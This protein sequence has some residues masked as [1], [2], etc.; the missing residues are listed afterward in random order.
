MATRDEFD[1]ANMSPAE[2]M[3]VAA[4]FLK[5]IGDKGQM[6]SR[7]SHSAG[8]QAC[9]LAAQAHMHMAEIKLKF[10]ASAWNGKVSDLPIR[11]VRDYNHQSPLY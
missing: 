11:R 4:D 9:A 6:L 5:A 3:E 1:P 8:D 10:P 7:I 2:H